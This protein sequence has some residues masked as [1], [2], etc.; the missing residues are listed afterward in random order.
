MMLGG[1]IDDRQ[2]K[3]TDT[4][5]TGKPRLSTTANQQRQHFPKDAKSIDDVLSAALGDHHG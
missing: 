5:Q 4:L 1:L 2:R 3:E